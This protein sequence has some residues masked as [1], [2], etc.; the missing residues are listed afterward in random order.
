MYHSAQKAYVNEESTKSRSLNFIIVN[1]NHGIMLLHEQMKENK[2]MSVFHNRFWLYLLKC[3][4]RETKVKLKV[5]S[6]Q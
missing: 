3:T 1:V 5:M 4:L 2:L 6:L